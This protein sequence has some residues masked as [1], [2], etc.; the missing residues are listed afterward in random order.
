M[1]SVLHG[2]F[3]ESNRKIVERGKIDTPNTPIHDYALS[4]LSTGTSI[5]C[6]GVKP[7]LLLILNFNLKLTILLDL[8]C[9]QMCHSGLF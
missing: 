2:I 6:G 1:N 3:Q 5:Q 4:W 9:Y 8:A 7:S